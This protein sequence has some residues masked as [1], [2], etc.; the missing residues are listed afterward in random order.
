VGFSKWGSQQ[1]AEII[2]RFRA[3]SNN[4]YYNIEGEAVKFST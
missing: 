2:T 4:P 1:V 3:V